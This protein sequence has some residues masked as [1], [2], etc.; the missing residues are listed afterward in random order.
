MM[1]FILN[2]IFGVVICILALAYRRKREAYDQY[3]YWTAGIVHG[4]NGKF[5][6]SRY[7]APTRD[8]LT[9]AEQAY[10]VVR[11][12]CKQLRE[13][14]SINEVMKRQLEEQGVLRKDLLDAH[15]AMTAAMKYIVAIGHL[16][17]NVRSVLGWG[18]SEV[19]IGPL[20]RPHTKDKFDFDVSSVRGKPVHRDK[21]GRFEPLEKVPLDYSNVPGKLEPIRTLNV[22]EAAEAFQ[23]FSEAVSASVSQYTQECT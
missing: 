4:L 1:S 10:N 2:L 8:E 23:K 17:E 13:T 3:V 11:L 7:Q 20:P 5:D 6:G 14:L 22:E 12:E 16:S 19:K 15:T 21:D 9:K 18:L